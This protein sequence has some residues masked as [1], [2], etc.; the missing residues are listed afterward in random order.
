M[1]PAIPSLA[2]PPA[3]LRA[4]VLAVK[5]SSRNDDQAVAELNTMSDADLFDLGIARAGIRE[6]VRYGRTDER[7]PT[8]R[9]SDRKAA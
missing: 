2:L 3:G 6:A 4:S 5:S 7:R 1:P 9:T 8:N